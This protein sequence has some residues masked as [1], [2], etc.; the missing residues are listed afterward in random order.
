MDGVVATDVT[1]GTPAEPNF[2]PTS[3]DLFTQLGFLKSGL[4]TYGSGFGLCHRTF[5]E[6]HNIFRNS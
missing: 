4:G 3:I 5:L 2:H 1:K 6:V